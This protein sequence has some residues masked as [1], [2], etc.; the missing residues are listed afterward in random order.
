[1]TVSGGEIT[2]AWSQVDKTRLAV[3][4][5]KSVHGLIYD[6]SV[7]QGHI[8]PWIHHAPRSN[9]YLRGFNGVSWNQ[10][11]C[12]LSA[13]LPDIIRDCKCFAAEHEIIGDNLICVLCP[14]KL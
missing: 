13:F 10:L 11:R 3:S 2:R 9:I 6:R 5:S 14:H 12:L 1:M 7:A 4:R 8:C